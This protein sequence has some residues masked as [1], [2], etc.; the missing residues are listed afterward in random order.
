[1][2]ELENYS[3]SKKI[4]KRKAAIKVGIVGGGS[5]GKE[6][7]I[8]VSQKS[9]DVIFI[10]VSEERVKKIFKLIGKQLDRMIDRW[11]MTKSEKRAILSRIEGS[12]DYKDLNDC[13]IVIES[14]ATNKPV[15]DLSLRREVF[16]KIEDSVSKDTVIAS[17]ASTIVIADLN[18]VLDYPNRA[19]GIHFIAPATSVKIIEV[20]KC[21][22]TSDKTIATVEKFAKMIDK[23]IINVTSSPGNI[24]TRLIIPLINEACEMLMEGTGTVEDIDKTLKL[25][26]GMQLGPFEMADKIGLEKLFKW[27]EGLYQE[28]GEKRYKT[29]PIIRRMLRANMIGMRVGEGFYKYEDGKRISKEGPICNLGRVN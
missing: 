13:T 3:L 4:K 20:N 12:V 14:V 2:N 17:N 23:T 7:A 5:S 27:M 25:G 1:M 29:S 9:I 28:Y 26:F 22:T 19:I 10:D 18:Y 6:I 24:S 16:K 21:I 11:G 15:S 8:I